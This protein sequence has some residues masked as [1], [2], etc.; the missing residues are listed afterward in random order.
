MTPH[1]WAKRT[2]MNRTASNSRDHRE[3]PS[4][5]DG[6]GAGPSPCVRSTRNTVHKLADFEGELTVEQRLFDDLDAG[7][8]GAGARF[9]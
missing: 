8:E 4:R 2:R 3:A 6:K 9:A 1:Q 5:L 7:G